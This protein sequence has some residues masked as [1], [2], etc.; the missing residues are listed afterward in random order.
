MTRFWITLDQGVNFVMNSLKRMQGGEI[1]VPKIPSANIIDIAKAIDPKKKLKF[2]GIRP[3]EKIHETMC[4][5]D[6]NHLVIEFKDHYV[7][8]PTIIIQKNINYLKNLKGEIGK[9]VDKNFEYISS[10][11]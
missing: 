9:K 4:P 5:I 8:K 1:F 11:N 10:K 3:G 6:D 2:I 7:I